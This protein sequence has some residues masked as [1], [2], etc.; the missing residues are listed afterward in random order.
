MVKRRGRQ[1]SWHPTPNF[2]TKP[3]GA[4][5]DLTCSGPLYM[6]DFHGRMSGKKKLCLL[7]ALDLFQ[8]PLSEIKSALTDAFSAEEVPE[9]Y[10]LE[11]SL[12]S[13]DDDRKT[14]FKMQ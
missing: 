13:S 11:F 14:E 7:E 3:M 12:D 4:S 5:T 2:H 1:L 6:V 9:N 8:N 10:L